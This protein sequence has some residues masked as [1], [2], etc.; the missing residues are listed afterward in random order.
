[1][2]THSKRVDRSLGTGIHQVF[3]NDTSVT[4]AV[5]FATGDYIDFEASLG[6]PARKLL[7]YLNGAVDVTLLLNPT[8][9][10]SKLNESAADD[11]VTIT[12]GALSVNGFRLFAS[13]G[14]FLTWEAPDG[15]PIKNLKLVA[16]S[17]AASSST[18]LT[19]MAF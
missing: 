17:G 11:S 13:A 1:M 19:F 4:G 9:T 5:T 8:V 3:T 7:I 2:A 10:R 15:F 18:N 6:R 16:Y 12:E 14:G